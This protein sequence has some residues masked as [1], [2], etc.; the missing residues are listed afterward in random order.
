MNKESCQLYKPH[1]KGWQ[2]CNRYLG[3]EGHISKN[4]PIAFNPDF[5]ALSQT[6]F[7]N[8]SLHGLRTYSD[9]FDEDSDSDKSFSVTCTEYQI[10]KLDFFRALAGPS[11]HC[12]FA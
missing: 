8:W 11:H 2:D 12:V 6:D 9:V 4:S 7:P 5:L 10:P 1:L 3:T